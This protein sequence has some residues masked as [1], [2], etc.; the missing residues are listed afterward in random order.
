MGNKI[1]LKQFDM[2]KI[3]GDNTVSIFI[4]K[5]HSGN[6]WIPTLYDY[7]ECESKTELFNDRCPVCQD[8]DIDCD[9]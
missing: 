3:I 6:G 5:R 2:S 1:P 4:G 8:L 9:L 7:P